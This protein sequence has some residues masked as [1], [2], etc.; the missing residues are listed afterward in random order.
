[1][2][3]R[4][5]L[6]RIG[7]GLVFAVYGVLTL[8][9][10]YFLLMRTFVPTS[11]S[12]EL[13]LWIPEQEPVNLDAQI[14]NLSVF[15]NL[16]LLKFKSDFDIP[17]LDYL[18]PRSTL[19]D[20]SE[21]YGID[22]E[23]LR[24]YFAPYGVFNGWINLLGSGAFWGA[25]VRTLAVTALSL[26][27]LNLLS[28]C[29]G[30]GLAGLR[31]KDQMLWYNLYLLKAIIPTML[32]ILPQFLVVKW[33]LELV[34]AYTRPGPVHDLGQLL[35]VV[36]LW[37]R[38]GAL[39]AMIMTAAVEAIPHELGEA[40]EVDGANPL[41]FFW[42]I[43]LPLLRVPM[44]SLTVIFLP[45]VWNDFLQPYVYLDRANTTLLPLIQNLSGQYTSNYQITYT[46]VFLS[47]VPLVIAYLIFR[48][49]FIQGAL[50]GAVKG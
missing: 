39:P 42:H 47:V 38:G 4:R 9:P 32:V 25:V 17:K 23:A 27:A 26:L 36:L 6:F 8:L 2:Q 22:E 49:W 34:P 46:S 18:A 44:A 35:V 31:R 40:A 45:L 43:Q 28:A 24:S 11:Q 29:T 21:T 19:R 16:D 33:L 3:R 50:A 1:M 41:Q 30:V 12:T 15:F 10:F 20:I 7:V 48:R 37:A 14:G 5:R 13:H